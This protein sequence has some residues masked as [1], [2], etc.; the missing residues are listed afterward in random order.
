MPPIQSSILSEN[1]KHARQLFFSVLPDCNIKNALE[2]LNET[3]DTENIVIGLGEVLLN[4]IP[5]PIPGIKTM[6][7]HTSNNITIPSTPYALWCC[8]NGTDRGA[9]FHLSNDIE[10]ALTEFFILED[11]IDCFQYDE[12]R[13]MSGYIDG[14]ENPE[15][16]EALKVAFVQDNSA[17]NGSSFVAVQQWLH[18]FDT[19]KQMSE[20]EKDDVI[21]RHHADNEE[22]DEAPESAHVKRA[23][24]ESFT[25]EAF[26]LRRSIPWTEGMHAGLMFIAYSHSFD[27]FEAILKR[28]MGKED[29]ITDGLFQFTRPVSGSYFWCPPAK[30]GKLDLSFMK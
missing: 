2:S 1:T 16:E 24:Q 9:L 13:D 3:I 14:T 15:G 29:G 8:M 30:D 11:S 6:P 19:L 20:K 28:M 5:T 17:L 25:P 18:D 26:L 22:F 21:G 27:A 4:E 23:A 7:A 12:N 10:D